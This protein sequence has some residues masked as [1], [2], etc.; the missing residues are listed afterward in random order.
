MN[1]QVTIAI[2]AGGQSRRM[3]TDKSF[4]LLNGKL[5][6]QH[7]IDRACQLETPLIL[8][9]NDIERYQQLGLPV[10]PDVLP[11]AGSL[12][13]LYT[14]L[15][16]SRTDYTLC[17]ACDMPQVNPALLRYLI[18]L[19]DSY[20]AIVPRVNGVAQSLH[21]IYHQRCLP[22]MREHIQQGKLKISRVID[23][24]NTRFVDDAELHRIDPDSR[25]FMNLNTQ[26][27]LE[28]FKCIKIRKSN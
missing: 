14:A 4:V 3:G 13:G 6:L 20:D 25:S 15:T 9:A 27:D 28:Q 24:L 19:K 1:D 21:A 18:T 11:G 22:I 23:L 5:L 26:V 8:I 10:Y 12:G 16:Y 7:V 2:L 17:L